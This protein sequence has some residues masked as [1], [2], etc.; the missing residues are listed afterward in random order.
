EMAITKIV[1][2]A[3]LMTVFQPLLDKAARRPC[4]VHHSS[5]KSSQND[6]KPLFINGS[7]HPNL[8]VSTH[9]PDACAGELFRFDDRG[10]ENPLIKSKTNSLSAVP[11]LCSNHANPPFPKRMARTIRTLMILNAY[12]NAPQSFLESHPG[13][14]QNQKLVPNRWGDDPAERA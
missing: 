12:E 2:K 10:R 6:L 14:L 7:D 13:R 11:I 4:H 8:I 1:E 9:H 3:W 5:P